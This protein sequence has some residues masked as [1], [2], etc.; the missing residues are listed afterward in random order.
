MD[1][2]TDRHSILPLMVFNHVVYSRMC[3][4]KLRVACMISKKRC[5]RPE[6][7][8]ERQR[9]REIEIQTYKLNWTPLGAFEPWCGYKVPMYRLYCGT[10]GLRT[11]VM[12]AIAVHKFWYPK[13]DMDDWT[14]RDPERRADGHI[15][16]T[17][18]HWSSS[19]PSVGINVSV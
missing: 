7:E 19:D 13:R 10:H 1:G 18:P 12:W 4:V 6:R 9:D 15:S 16:S 11:H 5:R 17:G 8:T 14:D 2:R 3:C